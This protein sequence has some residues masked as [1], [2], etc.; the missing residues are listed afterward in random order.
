MTV[1]GA[2]TGKYCEVTV[3]GGLDMCIELDMIA[4]LVLTIVYLSLEDYQKE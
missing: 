1:F 2:S 4:F 3:L